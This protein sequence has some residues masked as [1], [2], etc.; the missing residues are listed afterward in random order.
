MKNIVI[1]GASGHGAMILDCL[2]KE[3]KYTVI[4]FVDSFKEKGTEQNGYKVLGCELDLPLLI[5]KHDLHGAILA[6]GN[7]W[8]RKTMADSLRDIAPS[9]D[10]VS[11][12][13]PSA[14][15]GK[16]VKIGKGCV[17]MP[18]SIV[19]ASSKMGDFCILNTNASLGHDSIMESFSSIASGVCTGGN[20]R[21]G[22]FSA[23]SLGAN[24]IENIKIG[25]HSIIG[26]GSLVVK[27][28]ESHTVVYGSPA[29]FIR[30]RG[31]DD[32]YLSGDTNI[33]E[34]SVLPIKK[35]GS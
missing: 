12:I 26:A 30:K 11:A 16:D 27:D 34:P 2:E 6:I 15:I 21:L 18:G 28:V 31:A 13:H 35:A 10:F 20:L 14:S 32:P 4:G 24:I 23:I 19:N 17:L 1:V 25:E 29:R 22:A 9:L 7:N 3:S 8:T 33:S 5:A